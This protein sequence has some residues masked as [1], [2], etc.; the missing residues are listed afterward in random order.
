MPSNAACPD[1]STHN[2]SNAIAQ[3][4][5]LGNTNTGAGAFTVHDRVM[6]KLQLPDKT[7]A[8]LHMGQ[9]DFVLGTEDDAQ[10]DLEVHS[11]SPI[12]WQG[13]LPSAQCTYERQ[14]QRSMCAGPKGTFFQ[15]SRSKQDLHS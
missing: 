8:I 13:N 1:L 12:P 14:C 7:G 2:H 4:P 5:Y 15:T 10:H 9:V 3:S 6:P 11:M